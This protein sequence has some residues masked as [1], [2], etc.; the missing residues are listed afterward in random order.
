MLAFLISVPANF[1]SHASCEARLVFPA[2]FLDPLLISTHTPLARRDSFS[3]SLSGS[4]KIST[5]TPLARRDH[6][7]FTNSMFSLISTHTPLARRDFVLKEEL[8]INQIS[9]HTPLARRDTRLYSIAAYPNI[10]THTPLARRDITDD[11]YTHAYIDF[12]SHASCEARRSTSRNPFHLVSISTHTP[13]ARRDFYQS[14]AVT[15]M[16]DFYSHA[17]CEARLPLGKRAMNMEKFLLTRLLRGATAT[18]S[19]RNSRTSYIQEADSKIITKYSIKFNIL[20]DPAIK[21]RR[22]C[23]S[24][25]HHNTFACYSP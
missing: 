19:I 12:Y 20:H 10:S 21:S 5:H 9:T 17:S 13:L 8:K 16:Q 22:T 3:L 11:V 4:E 7:N 25:M 15:L 24:F 14:G 2:V 18:Y 1:Y 6:I 23:L